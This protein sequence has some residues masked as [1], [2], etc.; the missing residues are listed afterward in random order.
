MTAEACADGPRLHL[1][2]I[3]VRIMAI[4]AC[5]GVPALSEALAVPQRRDLIR[6]QKI[7][8][9]RIRSIRKTAVALA[10]NGELSLAF[11]NSRLDHMRP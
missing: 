6:N 4:R 5:D 1:G 10:A 3:L 11:R 7:V 2:R 8:G 9:K